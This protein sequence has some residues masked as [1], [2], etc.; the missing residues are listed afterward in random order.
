MKEGQCVWNAQDGCRQGRFAVDHDG[1]RVTAI[2]FDKKQR[3]LVTAANDGS[4]KMWN[5]NNGSALRSFAHDQDPLEISEVLFARDEKRGADTVYA[6]GWNAKVFVW[7][8]QDKDEVTDYKVYEGHREDILA[9]AAYPK[10]QLLATGD[11]QGHISIWNLFT[12]ERKS[13][14]S[15]RAER[16]ETSVERLL[17]VSAFSPQQRQAAAAR[18]AA[19]RAA[20]LS[21]SATSLAIGASGNTSSFFLG[22]SHSQQQP[23]GSAA[24]AAAGSKGPAGVPLVIVP[25]QLSIA[26]DIPLLDINVSK[27]PK[28]QHQLHHHQQQFVVADKSSN[29]IANA[30]L[31]DSEDMEEPDAL[32]MLSAGGD[33]VCQ[34]WKINHLGQGQLLCTL[35]G[36]QGVLDVVSAV[37]ID[38]QATAVV[39]GDSAGHLRVYD[40]SAGIDTSSSDAAAASFI[41]RAH[42]Q[43]HEGGI[44]SVDI[45]PSRPNSGLS[46]C[47]ATAAA[48]M[49][50]GSTSSYVIPA[51]IV[52]ASRDANVAVWTLDGGLVGVLGE[53]SWDLDNQDTWQDPKGLRK[54]PPRPADDGL[55]VKS[56][57]DKEQQQSDA[58]STADPGQDIAS[59]SSATG[60]LGKS[61]I[62]KIAARQAGRLAAHLLSAKALQQQSKQFGAQLVQPAAITIANELGG[63]S[64]ATLIMQER[65]QKMRD[66]MVAKPEQPHCQLH[67]HE[68]ND[69]DGTANEILKAAADKRR[70]K[71]A[72]AGG[73][74][75]NHSAS[76]NSSWSGMSHVTGRS[77]FN[78][79]QPEGRR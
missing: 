39:L 63:L 52:S 68:L 18:A 56:A 55:Y 8:D 71:A 43:A 30:D 67:I 26:A 37:N 44:S 64:K 46:S 1:S 73:R 50:V 66:S 51:L 58:S 77:G 21:A 23:G 41:K 61:G 70:A 5:F 36:A 76:G 2:S 65:K 32:L 54:K 40:I 45:V 69:V 27:T 62:F 6:A 16:C 79:R 72:A 75:F 34:V 3:R 15:H 17:W 78:W 4:I 19:A 42:W 33:G 25:S 9:M 60:H 29:D 59:S 35:P 74:H 12:G 10:R 47:G 20:A 13:W 14:L 48:A 38:E 22:Q 24:A 11:Y 53:H 49:A 28:G 57:S 7:E 31:S